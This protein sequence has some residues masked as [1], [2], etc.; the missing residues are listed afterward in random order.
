MGL[1]L[2]NND[3]NDNNIDCISNS[4]TVNSNIISGNECT[5]L[6]DNKENKIIIS[7]GKNSLIKR[8]RDRSAN[9]PKIPMK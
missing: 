6:G 2:N 8:L 5:V 7:S 1:D 9:P 3:Y 4:I